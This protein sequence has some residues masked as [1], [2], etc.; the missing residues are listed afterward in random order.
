MR[1]KNTITIY[2]GLF[3]LRD[4]VFA[5]YT[6][7]SDLSR[8]KA[9]QF[10]I[11][12]KISLVIAEARTI[13]LRN[14][15]IIAKIADVIDES[16][17]PLTHEGCWQPPTDRHNHVHK[18]PQILKK[19]W[20]LK[21]YDYVINN[22]EAQGLTHGRTIVRFWYCSWFTLHRV[23]QVDYECIEICIQCIQYQ[24]GFKTRA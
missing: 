13:H 24:R 9:C 3:M 2:N 12:R 8:T 19:P 5:V 7:G 23:A 16:A 1:W 17:G 18:V 11:V 14:W 22:N 4:L 10:I 21:K 6:F 15:T 20:E